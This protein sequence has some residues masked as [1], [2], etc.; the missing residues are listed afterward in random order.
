MAARRQ[1][2]PGVPSGRPEA[3]VVRYKLDVPENNLIDA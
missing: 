2:P 1:H 3:D